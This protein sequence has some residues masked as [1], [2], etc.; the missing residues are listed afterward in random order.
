MEA[1]GRSM[2]RLRKQSLT[3]GQTLFV[4][5]CRQLNMDNSGIGLDEHV[6][7]QA[8]GGLPYFMDNSG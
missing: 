5:T 2:Q 1:S 4:S 8:V 6:Y 7:Q 3:Q